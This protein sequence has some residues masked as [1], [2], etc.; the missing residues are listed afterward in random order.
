MFLSV[1]GLRPAYT[2]VVQSYNLK[3]YIHGSATVLS[4]GRTR[5]LNKSF[6]IRQAGGLGLV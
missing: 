5:Y 6:R 1:Q 2:R 4:P 3:P